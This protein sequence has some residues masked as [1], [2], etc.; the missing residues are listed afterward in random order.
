ML[1]VFF[2]GFLHLGCGASKTN[3]SVEEDL[4]EEAQGSEHTESKSQKTVQESSSEAKKK[5]EKVSEDALICVEA[6]IQDR[7]AEAVSAQLIEQQCL[8]GCAQGP[9]STL[10]QKNIIQKKE[11]QQP[12][13]PQKEED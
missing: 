10:N 8:D 1:N 6:C 11:I 3:S 5:D 13:T 12:E 4:S 7:R 9:D 2:L